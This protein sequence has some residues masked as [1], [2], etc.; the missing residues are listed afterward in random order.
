MLVRLVT[1]DGLEVVLTEKFTQ[2]HLNNGVFPRLLGWKTADGLTTPNPERDEQ[3]RLTILKR[4]GVYHR[5]L[6]GL[7]RF[8]RTRRLP[9]GEVD[10]AYYV[11]ICLGGLPSFDAHVQTPASEMLLPAG[12]N[13]S[14][15]S[16]DTESRFLWAVINMYHSK[17]IA[18]L[19]MNGWSVTSKMD[20]NSK[21]CPSRLTTSN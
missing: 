10:D 19:V 21:I 5:P 3:G 2:Q 4:L 8:L 6:L 16:E 17:E 15:P 9:A 12:Y 11:S 20:E 1:C 13:P 18:S 7:L 14:K